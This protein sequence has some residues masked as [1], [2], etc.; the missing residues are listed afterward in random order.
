MNSES[1][2]ENEKSDDESEDDDVDIVLKYDSPLLAT[3]TELLVVNRCKLLVSISTI[4]ITDSFAYILQMHCASHAIQLPIKKLLLPSRSV[5]LSLNS[6]IIQHQL[7][8]VFALVKMFNKGYARQLLKNEQTKGKQLCLKLYCETRWCYVYLIF[9]RFLH[10]R[11]AITCASAKLNYDISC[12]NW[13]ILSEMIIVLKPIYDA[14][15]RSQAD[16][17]TL[18]HVYLDI[19]GII[20]QARVFF[21]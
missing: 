5:Q 2:S 9:E 11:T 16:D 19:Q 13:T 4:F 12:V 8:T 6:T 21:C 3:L 10:L 7:K 17:L 20:N 15:M 1:E 18:A 14:T